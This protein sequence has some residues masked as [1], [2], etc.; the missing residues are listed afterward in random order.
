MEL[1]AVPNAFSPNYYWLLIAG[2]DLNR[3]PAC[4]NKSSLRLSLL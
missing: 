4:S 1:P 2:Q 3:S